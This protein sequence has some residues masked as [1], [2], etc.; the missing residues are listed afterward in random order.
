MAVLALPQLWYPLWFDQ[1]AFAACA[2]VIRRGG[3]M[4]R[5]CWEVRGPL[6]AFAYTI[7]KILS[8]SPVFVHGFDLVCAAATSVLIGLLV[9]EMFGSFGEPLR[10][11][12]PGFAAGALYWLM[13][14]GLNYW[15]TAQAEGFANVVLVAAGDIIPGDG[16]VIEGVASVNEAAITGE[17]APVIRESGGDRCAVTG[18]TQVIS[19]QIKVKITAAPGHSFLDRMIALV[20]G[21]ERQKTPNEIALSLVLSTFTLIFLVV[22]ATLWPMARYAEQYMAGYL[23]A[24]GLKS[25]GTDIPTL[26]ALLVHH[27]SL[28]HPFKADEV[29]GLARD[30]VGFGLPTNA[31]SI[32]EGDDHQITLVFAGRLMHEKQLTFN[33]TWPDVLTDADGQC[34]GHAR[35]TL[36]TSPP[37]DYRYNAELV[38]VNVSARLQQAV[39]GG[40]WKGQL[41]ETYLPIGGDEA[42]YE[43]ERIE[44]G[45]KWSPVKTY[46][47]DIP[48]GIGKSSSWRLVVDYLTRANEPFPSAGVPFTVILTIADP[49]ETAPVFNAMRQTLQSLGIQITDIRTAARVVARV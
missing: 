46:G 34:R 40:K 38:R 9:R 27:A 41:H 44:H 36:V 13:Y 42:T 33:F 19:D 31:S 6:A 1:G 10:S 29:A 39:D 8:I 49:G 37:L 45:F 18:G 2:D 43:Y 22:T 25:L 12:W 11:P 35:L 48:K 47:R 15:S 32:L 30:L 5:D 21:A 20:E 16:D 26:V 7:P 24:S 23:G 14:V 4:Y 28:P 3:V 17:S